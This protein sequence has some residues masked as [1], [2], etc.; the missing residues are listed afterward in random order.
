MWMRPMNDEVAFRRAIIFDTTLRDGEQSPGAAMN[1]VEKVQLALQLARLGVDVIEAG[2]PASSRGDAE[3]VASVAARVKGACLAAM[4]RCVPADVDVAWDALKGA[5][6]PRLHLVMPTS[7]RHI[8]TRLNMTR[9]EVLNLAVAAVKRAKAKTDDVQFS[10]E[11]ATRTDLVFLLAI[12]KAAME[13]G[14][15]TLNIA[16]TTG[17][18]VPDQFGR[19][20]GRVVEM[21]GPVTVGVHCHDDLGMATANSMAGVA[22]GAGQVEVTINGIGERAGNTPLEEVVMA[23]HARDDL[24]LKTGV[25]TTRILPVSRLVSHVTGIVVQPNK[26]V[27]GAN[28]LVHTAGLHQHAVLADEKTYQ[29]LNPAD[30]G[31]TASALP[32]TRLTGRAGL[33]ERLSEMGYDL[34]EDDFERLFNRFKKLAGKKR[35]V[36]AEDLAVLMADEVLRLPQRFSLVY[37]NVVSG[38]V[39][40]PTATVQIMDDGELRQGA[41]FG[42]GPVDATFNTIA[43][44]TGSKAR[45]LRFTVSAVTGGIDALGEVTVRLTEDDRVVLGKGADNDIIT[46][47]AKAFIHGLNRLEQLKAH[48]A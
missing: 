24:G 35:E 16:D 43:Q 19:L 2:F 9:D 23:I 28:A 29:I 10:A 37:L 18:A 30:L 42:V 1:P 6:R 32:L 4:A 39:A 15:T 45:L 17:F 33:K 11:D 41:G 26:A 27:V 40:V 25:D 5:E 34:S 44:I 7:D 31:L 21:A 48:G 47:S 14:A 46:A 36:E 12:F 22:A 20:V 38:T 8:S 3:A 13:A